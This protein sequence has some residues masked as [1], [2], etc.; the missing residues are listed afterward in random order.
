MG[1]QVALEVVG[2][3]NQTQPL[4]Q[5]GLRPAQRK[6]MAA[7]LKQQ[8]VA[9]IWVLVV[10]VVLMRLEATHLEQM[11]ETGVLVFHPP[12][13]VPQFPVEAE[14]VVGVIPRL[15]DQREPQR[16]A[17]E[18]E[19]ITALLVR[20]ERETQVVVA[21]VVELKMVESEETAAMAALVLSFLNTQT[22]LLS[23]ILAVD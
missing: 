18:T 14:A 17:G 21:G 7:G 23:P 6:D 2:L 9:M 20:L 19:P 1:K 5:V 8:L 15:E 10:G 4:E 11:E 3:F 16:M 12:L 13:R 22:P